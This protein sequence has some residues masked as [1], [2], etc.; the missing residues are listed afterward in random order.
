MTL[1]KMYGRAKTADDVQKFCDEL[2]RNGIKT[3]TGLEYDVPKFRA[4]YQKCRKLFA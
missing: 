1:E 2:N 4:M 3:A